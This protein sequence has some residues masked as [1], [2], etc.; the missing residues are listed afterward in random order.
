[1]LLTLAAADSIAWLMSKISIPGRWLGLTA[2]RANGPDLP[3]RR[4]RVALA[5][6]SQIQDLG[7]LN[8]ALTRSTRRPAS[9]SRATRG[10][11]EQVLDLTGWPLY[12]SCA[13]GYSFADV[14]E[15][16]ADPHTRWI[17]VRQPHVEG[18]WYYSQ[19]LREL[20]GGREPVALVPPHATPNQ[21][22]IRIYDRQAPLP[23]MAA[24][25]EP[26][27]AAIRSR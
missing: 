26:P 10:T 11:N 3:G 8:R 20:I 17:V 23:Q 9:G 13:A 6:D 14:Y 2:N 5:H 12:F 21:V 22:Q 24:T 4:G 1:M 19:V 25:S 18:H 7:P 16:P 15:A 27:D